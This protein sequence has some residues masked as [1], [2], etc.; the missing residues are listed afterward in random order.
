VTFPHAGPSE[1]RFLVKRLTLGNKWNA[2]AETVRKQSYDLRPGD[3]EQSPIWEYALDEEGEPGEDEATVRPRPD[4]TVADPGDGIFVARAEF[5]AHDGTRYDGY[6]SPSTEREFGFIQPTIVTDEG[7]VSFWY[8]AFAPKP[9]ALEGDYKL[10][11]RPLISSSRSGS[12]R[13]S[14]TRAQSSRAKSPPSCITRTSAPGKSSTSRSE[15]SLARVTF[16]N[17]GPSETQLGSGAS[18]RST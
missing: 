17:T 7:Q 12:G 13:S 8:G 3:L 9:G 5:I 6:V 1:R 15:H 4:L 10:L 14:N 16:P 2:V 18:L 11:E